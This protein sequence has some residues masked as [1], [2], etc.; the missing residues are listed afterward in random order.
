MMQDDQIIYPELVEQS[1]AYLLSR[2]VAVSKDVVYRNM[3]KF[4]LIDQNGQPTQKAIN[5]GLVS[6]TND[7]NSL[8]VFK[9]QNPLFLPYDDRHFIWVAELQEWTADLYVAKDVSK[10]IL[11]GRVVGDKEH[12]KAVLNYLKKQG[13]GR[14]E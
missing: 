8:A 10:R 9:A 14:Y 4:H 11:D 2:G 3:I 5:E 1:H 13:G 7:P 12:A 6:E